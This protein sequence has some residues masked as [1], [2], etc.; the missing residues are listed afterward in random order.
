[1]I[2]FEAL[3]R[4]YAADV[5]RFALYLTGNPTRAEDIVSETFVR[6]WGASDRIRTAKESWT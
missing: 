1:M 4:R 3:Y 6:V 5:Y 2:E